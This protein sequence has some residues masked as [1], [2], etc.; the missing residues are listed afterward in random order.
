MKHKRPKPQSEQQAEL[1]ERKL[2]ELGQLYIRYARRREKFGFDSMK[3]NALIQIGHRLD[4]IDE[5][6]DGVSVVLAKD[7]EIFKSFSKLKKDFSN[8]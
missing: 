5:M 6:I 3:Q 4:E 2:R 7:I 1:L 8:D